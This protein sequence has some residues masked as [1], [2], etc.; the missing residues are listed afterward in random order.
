MQEAT[1][2]PEVDMHVN[3]LPDGDSVRVEHSSKL[4]PEP[5]NLTFGDDLGAHEPKPGEPKDLVQKQRC[6]GGWRTLCNI[7]HQPVPA[8]FESYCEE[9][10]EDFGYDPHRTVCFEVTPCNVTIESAGYDWDPNWAAENWRKQKS[11]TFVGCAQCFAKLGVVPTKLPVSPMRKDGSIPDGAIVPD[12]VV[13]A[14]EDEEPTVRP[15]D[16][17]ELA[18]ID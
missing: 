6:Y 13:K 11:M 17:L 10:D 5:L 1:S 16:L 7:C 14:P 4:P 18:D 15:E 9:G 8:S 3:K 2:N 12:S